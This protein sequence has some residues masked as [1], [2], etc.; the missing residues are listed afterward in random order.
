MQQMQKAKKLGLKPK[1]GVLLHGFPG[2]GKTSVARAL[3]R[4]MKGKFFMIDGTFI[5]EPPNAFFSR[6]R[7]VFEAA[8]SNSPSVASLTTPTFFLKPTTCMDLTAIC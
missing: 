4:P 2:T 5:T 6:V 1:R 8:K 7:S 3:A